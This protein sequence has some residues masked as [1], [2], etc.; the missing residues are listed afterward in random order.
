MFYLTCQLPRVPSVVKG[1][2]KLWRLRCACRGVCA[3]RDAAQWKRLS[4]GSAHTEEH[5]DKGLCVCVRVRVGARDRCVCLTVIWR[6]HAHAHTRMCHQTSG[7]R[8][9]FSVL[10]RPRLLNTHTYTLAPHWFHYYYYCHYGCCCCCVWV[11]TSVHNRQ[12]WRCLLAL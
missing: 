2:G 12:N 11:H 3:Q 5:R 6:T 4:D 9:D 1:G 8:R 7:R 10:L